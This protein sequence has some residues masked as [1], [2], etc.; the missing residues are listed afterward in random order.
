M[1]DNKQLAQRIDGAIQSASQEVTNLRSELSATGRRLAELGAS[2][3]S[4]GTP[5]THQHNHNGKETRAEGERERVARVRLHAG[6]AAR[7][8]RDD[9]RRCCSRTC[10]LFFLGGDQHTC[11]PSVRGALHVV[12]AFVKERVKEKKEE[13]SIHAC[14]HVRKCIFEQ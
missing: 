12:G 7:R 4:A 14:V 10:V 11:A 6:N 5:E 9:E 2:D 8:R 3:P 1:D 13:A